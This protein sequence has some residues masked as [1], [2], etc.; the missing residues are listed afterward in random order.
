MN[1]EEDPS[2]R[3]ASLLAGSLSLSHFALS[4]PGARAALDDPSPL[5]GRKG[6]VDAAQAVMAL[7]GIAGL[8]LEKRRRL[9]AIAARDLNGELSLEEV[10]RALANLA[11]A[12]LVATLEWLDGPDGLV[13]VGMGKLGGRELNYASDIDLIFAAEGDIG[14]AT[15]IATALVREL[16]QPSP[17][18]QPFRIDLALRP[19][20]KSGPLVRS[21][22]AFVEYYNRWAKPWE[23]QAFIKA[24]AIAGDEAAGTALLEGL[25]PIVY[26]R[27]ITGERIESIRK[28]KERVE[29]HSSRR[30]GSDHSGNVKLGAGG[31]RDIEFSVQLLQLVHGGADDSVRSPNTLE[32][33]DRLSEGAYI[34]EEDGVALSEAYRWLRSVEHRLQLWRERQVHTLP[35]EAEAIGRIAGTMGFRDAPQETAD[36]QFLKAHK[37]VLLDVRSRFEKLFYRPMIESLVDSEEPGLSEEGLK[38]RL[39]VLGFRDVGRAARTLSE[40]VS[41][42]SR[43]ARILRVLTPPLL[44]RLAMTPLPDE[45]LFGFLRISHALEVQP[46]VLTKLR[47]NP[48]GIAFLAD[49]LGSGRALADVLTHVP[50]ELMTIAAGAEPRA[51]GMKEEAVA[52][53]ERLL[54]EARASLAWRESDER[55]DGLRRFKRRKV[56]SVALRDLVGSSSAGCVGHELS[57]L[58]EAC[59]EVALGNSGNGVAVIGMGKLGGR[60]LSYASD[61]DVMF[62]HN[63]AAKEPDKVATHVLHAIAEVTPEGKTFAVDTGLRPEGKDG[64]LVRSLESCIEYYTRWARP[65]EHQALIKAR[66]VAGDSELGR[67]FVTAIRDFAFPARLR[68]DAFTEIRHLK[69]RMERERIPRGTEPRR[70]IKLGPGGITDVEFSAQM[71]Q[72]RHGNDIEALRVHGTVEALEAAQSVELI[73]QRDALWLLEAYDFLA[74]LRNRLFFM[75]GRAVDTLPVRPEDLEAL[76]VALGYTGQPRQE[77]EEAYLRIT[78]RARRVAERLIYGD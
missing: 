3:L 28:M 11:D 70:H 1:P 14:K 24:R 56:L 76:G 6:Y 41:G 34:A 53:R 23:Y 4:D 26:E 7:D 69:A 73:P 68:G 54:K 50:E 63:S 44:R 18:G 61:L 39:R 60:E 20:G 42:S 77:V 66:F 35:S 15:R 37:A 47:D 32:A 51:G 22:D 40:L 57:V 33:L 64:P 71:L 36:A 78:R 59:L 8:R 65:W 12:C 38:V 72:L 58:A 62:V 55:L 19:E 67:D 30:A 9:A 46:V 21:L 74:R 31:I 45:G 43:R 2:G 29:S 27:E 13:V 16:G 48:P 5:P 17:Q 10:G 75:T 49:V 52:S 25:T